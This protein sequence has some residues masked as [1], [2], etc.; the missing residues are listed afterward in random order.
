MKK[1]K[2]RMRKTISSMRTFKILTNRNAKPD[3]NAFISA[4]PHHKECNNRIFS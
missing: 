4:W 2:K 3:R 1:L